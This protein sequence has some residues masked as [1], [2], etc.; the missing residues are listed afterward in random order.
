MERDGT[1][2]S[3]GWRSRSQQLASIGLSL[4]LAWPV[5]VGA[6]GCS[7]AARGQAWVAP[8]RAAALVEDGATLLD[9]RTPT[10]YASGHPAA[11]VNV[12]VDEVASR[13]G[14]I[15]PT[16]PVVVYCAAGVRSARAAAILRAE[17]Y[18]VYDLGSV[19]RWSGR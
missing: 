4:G 19:D 18:E 7:S 12:P 16:R 1:R 10:E 15:D 3:G 8:D 13:L 14:E 5:A 11:A 9:V 6:L 17:G 2:V